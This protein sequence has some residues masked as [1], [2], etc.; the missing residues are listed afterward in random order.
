MAK[1]ILFGDNYFKSK[2]AAIKEIRDRI[3]KYEAEENLN[4]EDEIF[5]ARLF[6]LHS[7]YEEKIGCGISHI[8]VKKD[9]HNNKCLYI[10]R[11]DGTFTDI[12][13]VHCVQPASQKTILS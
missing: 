1:P 13:W 6:E 8:Q 9:F 12:S 11:M 10:H 7:E 2:N 4:K 3:S 5:F